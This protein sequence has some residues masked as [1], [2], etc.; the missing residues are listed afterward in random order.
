MFTA[1]EQ[2]GGKVSAQSFSVLDRPPSLRPS[3]GPRQHPTVFLQARVYADRRNF[4]IRVGLNGRGR[5]GGLVWIDT[6]QH[7]RGRFPSRDWAGGSAADNP[8]SRNLRQRLAV[9]PLLSQAAN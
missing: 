5:V 3:R 1:C 6:D 9:T 8:T 7:H 4:P 2:P